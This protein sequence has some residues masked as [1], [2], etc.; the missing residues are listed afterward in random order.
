MRRRRGELL[1]QMCNSGFKSESP[2]KRIR[3]D[4]PPV[5]VPHINFPTPSSP[6]RSPSR[7]KTTIVLSTP[8]RQ[9]RSVH[10]SPEKHIRFS[11]PGE[12]HP[13]EPKRPENWSPLTTTSITLDRDYTLPSKRSTLKR[14]LYFKDVVQGERTALPLV[15]RETD[16]FLLSEDESLVS[17]PLPS[18][19]PLPSVLEEFVDETEVQPMSSIMTEEDKVEQCGENMLTPSQERLAVHSSEILSTP[20]QESLSTPSTECLSTPST[21][22]QPFEIQHLTTGFSQ[23]INH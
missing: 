13:V 11:I 10:T 4:P 18:L 5:I 1:V 21:E 20:S 23:H 22:D 9:S 15:E 19:P 6:S 2:S 12:E 3:V 14:L 8:P 7:K 16:S 17:P